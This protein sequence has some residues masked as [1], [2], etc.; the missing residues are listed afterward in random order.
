[1][2]SESGDA[3]SPLLGPATAIGGGRRLSWSG[4]GRRGR[5]TRRNSVNS[6]KNDFV[7]RLPDKVRSGVDL[8]S[9]PYFNLSKSVALTEG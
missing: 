4:S 2:D 9:S 3:K 6:L 1:M 8:E 5:L 7:S